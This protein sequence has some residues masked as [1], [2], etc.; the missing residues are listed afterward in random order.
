MKHPIPH[1]KL[2]SINSGAPI[3]QEYGFMATVPALRQRLEH[4]RFAGSAGA[5]LP[6][7]LPVVPEQH[8]PSP[9]L[10]LGAC[11]RIRLH[12][13]QPFRAAS[14]GR[15]KA[16]RYILSDSL[17]VPEQRLSLLPS[18]PNRGFPSFR[19]SRTEAFPRSRTQESLVPN[20]DF[21]RS[22]TLFGNEEAEFGKG[23]AEVGNE[24]EFGNEV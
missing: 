1:S 8:F 14:P 7:L 6:R 4:E 22:R 11:P 23:E 3:V 21:P 2:L 19:R 15:A 9:L 20:R 5:S 24:T 18:F 13:A 17:L 12:V 10:S 16:P